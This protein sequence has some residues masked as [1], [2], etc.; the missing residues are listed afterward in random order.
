MAQST[1][2]VLSETV[3]GVAVVLIVGSV[4]VPLLKRLRQPPV[5][6]E[7]LAGIM[8]GP[9]LLGLLPGDLPKLLFPPETRFGLASIAQVG[10][11][12]FMFLVGWETDLG[13]I[14]TRKRTVVGISLSAIALPCVTGMALAAWLWSNHNVV[15]GKVIDETA[16]ML[17]VGT[18]MAI[19]AFPV[20]ARIIQDHRLQHTRVGTLA[21][22]SAAVDDAM[23]WCLLAVVSVIAVSSG[24]GHVVT[25]VAGTVLYAVV[26]FAVAR[27]LLRKLIDRMT[28]N[29]VVSPRLLPVIAAGVFLCGYTT[30]AIGLDAIFGAFSFGLIMPRDGLKMLKSQVAVPAEHVTKL[31]LPIF[32]ITTG[33]SVD[34]TQLGGTGVVELLAI[35]AVACFGKYVGALGAARVSG[36]SWQESSL[37]GVLM[38]TRGLTE[39]IILNAGVSMGVLDNRMFTMM[40]LM[41]LITT[42]MAGPLVPR[43]PYARSDTALPLDGALLE[44]AK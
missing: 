9:S 13:M 33:L 31:L 40:V 17:F 16:F 26:L 29:G 21:L 37:I 35:L 44:P 36:L 8:L 10:I 18:A 15:N 19:T 22:A 12:I 42:A 43:Q 41:A 11:L 23:A 28:R 1:A 25:V 38:N 6:A 5:I 4:L 30:H 7:I 3:A 24:S 14:R 32:F 34:V 20:L 39:L 27:P 2:T